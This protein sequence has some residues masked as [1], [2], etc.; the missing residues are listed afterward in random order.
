MQIVSLYVHAYHVDEIC[1]F[2]GYVTIQCP[3]DAIITAEILTRIC[4]WSSMQTEFLALS[5]DPWVRI[6]RSA[7]ETNV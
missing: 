2:S 5:V 3:N 6:S 4:D 1:L 7:S